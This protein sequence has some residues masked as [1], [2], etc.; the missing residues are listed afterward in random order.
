MSWCPW[1]Q[2]NDGSDGRICET[3]LKQE[4]KKG[5]SRETII[6]PRKTHRHYCCYC[7]SLV[8]IDNADVRSGARVGP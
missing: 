4:L 2:T 6:K 3:C 7:G 5:E 1:C 8:D